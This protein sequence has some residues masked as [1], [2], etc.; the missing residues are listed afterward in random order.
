M[1]IVKDFVI[2]YNLERTPLAFA[3]SGGADSLAAVLIFH[4]L[5]P[6]LPIVAL[7]VD[8]GLRPTSNQEALFVADVMKKYGIEHHILY[9][10]GEKPVS[11]IEEKAR[12]A[13]YNLLFN[14]CHEHSIY[15]LVLAHHLFDQAETFLMR[16]Q[17]G[18][19]IYGLAAMSEISVRDGISLLRPFLNVHPRLFKDFL[20]AHHL[21]WVEDESN[22]CSDF[23]RV[24]MRKFLPLLEKETGITPEKIAYV[25][26]NLQNT[27]SFIEDTA[28]HIIQT[29]IH[30]WG[31]SGFSFDFTE[32]LSWHPELK[33]YIL[34][35]LIKNIGEL[36]YSPEAESILSLIQQLEQKNCEKMT[37]GGCVI[38][39]ANLKLW[40]VKE[41]RQNASFVSHC[42]WDDYIKK[43]PIFRGIYIPSLL[44]EALLKEK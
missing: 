10:G 28:R 19:G 37:L 32:F 4:D 42:S 11:G 12:E 29:K 1:Q 8:H 13:R 27:K 31:K 34:G 41:Y 16:L 33:F 9:W 6:K 2:K 7:T 20:I 5:F 21:Q 35:S 15:H 14:W 23:L 40:I 3:V 43:N 26:R 24:K 25:V 17:R 36:S 22:Q 39:K 44:K 18:T 38:L 30:Q